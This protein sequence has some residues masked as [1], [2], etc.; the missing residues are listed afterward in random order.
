[1]R[2]YVF[3]DLDD[4]LFQTRP[5][6]PPGV[7][8]HPAAF[9]QDGTAL[10][11]MSPIQRSFFEMLTATATVIPTTARNIDAF[12][13]VRLSFTSFAL[14][15]FAG[16][17]LLPDGSPDLA[18][19]AQIRPHA[20][21]LGDELQGLC[22]ALQAFVESNQ[23]GVTVRVIRDLEM[24]LYVVLKHPQGD[25]SALDRVRTSALMNLDREKFFV[26]AN[27]NNLSLIPRFLGKEKGVRYLL[28][29]H[30]NDGPCLTLGV[31]DSDTDAAFLAECDFAMMP[32]S[33][34]LASCLPF[35]AAH[36]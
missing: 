6:C 31:G 13:R 21:A 15:N 3:L 10:S 36:L 34:Q 9:R 27:D 1:M 24:P 19:D 17:I 30:L 22:Q 18:W 7:D 28:D 4:T 25:V 8:L 23:L 14:L 29:H 12:R 26:H 11:F 16:V 33:S 20:L 35:R 5:K 32:S 2:R